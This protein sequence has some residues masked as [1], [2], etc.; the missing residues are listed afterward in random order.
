MGSV[1]SVGDAVARVDPWVV[2]VLA[3]SLGY[4]L[5]FSLERL[6]DWMRS[7]R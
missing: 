6:S 7:E 2:L 5:S 3:F 4:L 1:V